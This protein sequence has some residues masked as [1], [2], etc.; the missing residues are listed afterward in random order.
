[1]PLT[2]VKELVANEKCNLRLYVVS[3]SVKLYGKN[4]SMTRIEA[5]DENKE[6]VQIIGWNDVKST[7]DKITA[8]SI[9]VFNDVLCDVYKENMQ[10]K[11]A[12]FSTIHISDVEFAYSFPLNQLKNAK[13]QEM[14]EVKAV[15]LEANGVTTNPRTGSHTRRYIVG[16]KNIECTVLAIN[17]ASVSSHLPGDVV[18]LK[19]KVGDN[20]NIVVFD[21]FPKVEDESLKEWWKTTVDSDGNRVNNT[22][23]TELKDI[24]I[25]MIGERINVVGII[26]NVALAP[27]HFSSGKTKRSLTLAD[28]TCHEVEVAI[29]GDD[30]DESFC[31]PGTQIAF[32]ATVS[33]WNCISLIMNNIYNDHVPVEVNTYPSLEAWWDTEGKLAT[34]ETLSVSSPSKFITIEEALKGENDRVSIRGTIEN[35]ILR[36][37]TGSIALVNHA[38]CVSSGVDIFQIQGE[39]YVRNALLSNTNND[40]IVFRTSIKMVDSNSY[41]KKVSQSFSGTGDIDNKNI[42]NDDVMMETS[43]DVEKP[44]EDEKRGTKRKNDGETV[45]SLLSGIVNPEHEK[46]MAD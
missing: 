39:A 45:P 38:S 44:Q 41:E 35:G 7:C 4:Q 42:G 13:P 20:K 34:F 36:D 3:K 18:F 29:F 40:L 27:V 46:M 6:L 14:I 11:I 17:D 8:G 31:K 28:H 25:S 12:Q 23:F 43:S 15:I 10:L 1:M 26:K 32:L 37:A 22:V 5:R 19:G 2:S 30:K 24:K 21:A 33:D 16:D 9:Y